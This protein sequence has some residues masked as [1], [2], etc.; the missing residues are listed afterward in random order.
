MSKRKYESGQ[1]ITSIDDLLKH[2]IVIWH[3]KAKN[4]AFIQNLQLHTVKMHIDSG[5]FKEAKRKE[6]E[7]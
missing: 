4:M 5:Y 7:G 6:S 2:D 1:I 3:G